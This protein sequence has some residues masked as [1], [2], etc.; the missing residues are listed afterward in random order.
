MPGV[1]DLDE[2]RALAS[3]REQ[4]GLETEPA[5]LGHGEAVT[6]E[7]GAAPRATADQYA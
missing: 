6:V 4:A 2:E 7:A 1:F 3:L 5:C